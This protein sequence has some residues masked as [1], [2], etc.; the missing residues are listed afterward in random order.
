[1]GL[2]GIFLKLV[3]GLLSSAS[4]K[5]HVNGSFTHEIPLTR[6]VRKGYPLSPL[7]FALSTQ[8]LMDYI[9][10]KLE[11][12]KIEGI[13]VK[14][15]LTICHRLFA[16]DVGIFIPTTENNF[17]KLKEI[18]LL[19]ELASGAKLNLSKSVIIPLAPP[20]Y[21]NGFMIPAT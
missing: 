11:V 19:Y 8:P 21:H 9:Q 16:D 15:G 10:Q 17:K 18:L 5:V 6:G 7:L 14:E 13:K 4:S 12:G 1:M 20:T 3:K 2:G